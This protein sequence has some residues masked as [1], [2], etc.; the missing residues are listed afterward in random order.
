MAFSQHL[1]LLFLFLTMLGSA[2][3]LT[4]RFELKSDWGQGFVG[5]V[6]VHNGGSSSVEGWQV[7]VRTPARFENVWNARQTTLP[8]PGAV[9]FAPQDYNRVI[10]PNGE[11]RFGFQASPGGVPL[12]ASLYAPTTPEVS[13]VESSQVR[14]TFRKLRAQG[15]KIVDEDNR[16]V[17]LRGV[18]WFGLE[19]EEFAPHG[20]WARSLDEMLDQIAGL[21]FNCLRVP[22]SNE[23]LDPSSQ[24]RSVNY[25]LN[26]DLLN[27]DGLGMLDALVE[28]AA[29][30]R[31]YV[32]LDR[33]RPTAKAQSALWYTPEV[34]EEQW[35]E[36]WVFLA[37]R[38][39]KFPNVVAADLHNEP[40]GPA[41]W[42]SGVQA[43]DWRLAAERCGNRILQ[44]NPDWLIVVEG[45]E[46]VG[47]SHYWWGGDLSQAERFPVRLKTP[48]RLVYSTH[49]YP[50]SVYPQPW[51]RPPAFPGN[52]SSVWTR[53][54]GYLVDKDM[55]P[56]FIGEFGTRYQTADDKI[57][58]K[59]LVDD[60]KKRE[61]SFT[62]WSWNPNSQDT[63]GLLK[64]DWLTVE[65]D[66]MNQL[67]SLTTR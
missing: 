24:P 8:E 57:W 59:H 52:L 12:E 65:A 10:P 53:H 38:Y 31:L 7:L 46:K 54:W 66:K 29:E 40:H 62:L 28:K 61:L 13:S 11:V 58:L 2:Q 4:V 9:L 21:G 18:N 17:T 16:V 41:D 36:D 20:L 6:V 56:V 1:A 34:S 64:D 44:A 27:L 51:L 19:T 22:F 5:E 25:A 63:G 30:R 23:L 35:I 43:T 15:S 37:K 50:S 49:E 47:N 42:G 26:P 3:P 60:I 33:H 39:A 32:I 45:V 48:N 14:P 67:R 55:A